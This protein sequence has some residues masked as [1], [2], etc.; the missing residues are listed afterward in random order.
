MQT[1]NVTVTQV[2]EAPVAGTLNETTAEDTGTKIDVL[3]ASSDADALRINTFDT[4]AS[5][6]MI[7]LEDNGTPG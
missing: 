7:S 5:L 4:T 2:N 1:I 3:A 6:G